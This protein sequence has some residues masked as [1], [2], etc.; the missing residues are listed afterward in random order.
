MQAQ[1]W[2][3]RHNTLVHGQVDNMT[4]LTKSAFTYSGNVSATKSRILSGDQTWFRP[5]LDMAVAETKERYLYVLILEGPV[6]SGVTCQ[7]RARWHLTPTESGRDNRCT[8]YQWSNYR[9][10]LYTNLQIQV[11]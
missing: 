7:G 5:I 4:V 3:S 8:R 2:D 6:N 10:T 11:N 9:N 1:G